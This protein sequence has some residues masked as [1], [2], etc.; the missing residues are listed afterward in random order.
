MTIPTHV[1]LCRELLV[2]RQQ[3]DAGRL[4]S[5]VVLDVGALRRALECR[6]D[7]ALH[8][9]VQVGF[10]AV[11]EDWIDEWI[12]DWIDDWIDEWIGLD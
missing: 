6:L 9:H 11:S 10:H 4:E 2:A 8:E 5:R 1:R 3:Q 7:L 12:D